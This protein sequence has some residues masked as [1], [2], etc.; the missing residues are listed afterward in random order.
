MA[1]LTSR[2]VSSIIRINR[3]LFY[4]PGYPL[5]FQRYAMSNVAP[6]LQL[7]PRGVRFEPLTA[8]GVPAAWVIPEGADSDRVILYLHGGG[9]VIG[10]VRSHSK[11][12]ARMAIAARCRALMIDYRLAPEHNPCGRRRRG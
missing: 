4:R 7:A 2:V 10:S 3:A 12:V 11:L 1:S 8:G 6:H 9:Y 5:R